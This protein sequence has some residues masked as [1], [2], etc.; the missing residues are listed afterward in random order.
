MP[1][2]DTVENGMCGGQASGNPVEREGNSFD[3]MINI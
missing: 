2:P 3:S 1:L